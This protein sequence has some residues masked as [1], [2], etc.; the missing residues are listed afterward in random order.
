[1]GEWE[2]KWGNVPFLPT[3]GWEPG[4]APVSDRKFYPY[5]RA[6]AR[7]LL[8]GGQDKLTFPQFFLIF[9]HFI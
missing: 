8:S 7:V 2:K 3:R 9:F 5:N 1:M 4:Y 6:V